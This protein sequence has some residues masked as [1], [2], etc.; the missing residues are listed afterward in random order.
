MVIAF[1]NI[2]EL[3]LLAFITKKIKDL[4]LDVPKRFQINYT[5]LDPTE[6]IIAKSKQEKWKQ[7]IE[8][9]K[10]LDISKIEN[11]EKGWLLS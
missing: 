4:I 5:K 2:S 11:I 3:N 9:K 8:I 1:F 10:E 7:R 6:I